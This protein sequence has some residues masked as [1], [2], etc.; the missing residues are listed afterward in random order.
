[1]NSAP[2]DRIRGVVWWL[3]V[4]NIPILACLWLI[5]AANVPLPQTGLL[6]IARVMAIGSVAGLAVLYFYL[7]SKRGRG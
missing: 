4:A 7:R 2:I 5:P 3:L 6:V 1:M